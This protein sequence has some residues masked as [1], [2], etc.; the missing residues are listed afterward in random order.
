[1]SLDGFLVFPSSFS[2]LSGVARHLRI[3]LA[4]NNNPANSLF[5]ELP[6]T[7]H[8]FTSVHCTIEYEVLYAGLITEQ[9]PN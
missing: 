2:H 7:T 4:C 5:G 8:C 3:E 9:S 1:M 6:T